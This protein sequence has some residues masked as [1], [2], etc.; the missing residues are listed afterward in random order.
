MS[1][2]PQF[3]G[4]LNLTISIILRFWW[5]FAWR[6]ILL[7]FAWGFLVS[8]ISALGGISA[9]ESIPGEIVLY[10]GALL[11]G[12]YV[13]KIILQKNFGR[14]KTCLIGQS[15][16]TQLIEIAPTFIQH[17]LIVWWA[18]LWRW[19]LWAVV[20]LLVAIV[21]VVIVGRIL[22]LSD[23]AKFYL[24]FGVGFLS[25]NLAAIYTL[26]LVLQKDFKTFKILFLPHS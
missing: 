20:F 21:P 10:L 23:V 19:L 18:W 24:A 9:T 4:Q 13:L 3:P 1:D 12:P 25:S 26:R 14:F 2:Q 16:S 11:V 8:F 17:G 7:S 22:E 6:S 5:S 15:A